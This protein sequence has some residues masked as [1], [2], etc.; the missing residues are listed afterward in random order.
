[1]T[2]KTYVLEYKF[3]AKAFGSFYSR[4]PF[5][6]ELRLVGAHLEESGELRLVAYSGN[7]NWESLCADQISPRHWLEYGSTPCSRTCVSLS[8]TAGW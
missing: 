2:K 6:H 3:L 8:S 7:K 1:M 4:R 5:S